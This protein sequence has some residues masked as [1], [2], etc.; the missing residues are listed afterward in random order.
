MRVAHCRKH[1]HRRHHSNTGN[2]QKDEVR[3]LLAFVA[4]LSQVR[5]SSCQLQPSV[6]AVIFQSA[7]QLCSRCPQVFVPKHKTKPE[8]EDPSE[9]QDIPVVRLFIIANVLLFGWPMYLLANVSGREYDGHAS[10]FDPYSP[11]F[12]KRERSEIVVSDAVLGLVLYGLYTLGSSIGWVW[13]CKVSCCSI[14]M[15]YHHACLPMSACNLIHS[16]LCTLR[17]Q[18]S[19]GLCTVSK[20]H[21]SIDAAFNARR[22]T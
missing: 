11:I 12:S 22:K 19:A 1:S 2:V 8:T 10:H 15:Q 5:V 4:S 16:N 13:F 7:L 21:V 17:G 18:F 9:W 20:F 6:F 14:C 3:Q